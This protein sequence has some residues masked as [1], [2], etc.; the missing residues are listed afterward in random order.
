MQ[1]QKRI[2][3]IKQMLGS[4]LVI[5]LVSREFWYE[6]ASTVETLKLANLLGRGGIVSTKFCRNF[7][8]FFHFF[9]F[10]LTLKISSNFSVFWDLIP[11][12]FLNLP[13]PLGRDRGASKACKTVR[14]LMSLS[15]SSAL[16]SSSSATNWG[17]FLL[18]LVI[19]NEL[20]N[21]D[22]ITDCS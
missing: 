16:K 12:K 13:V 2:V 17:W 19:Q 11:T 22:F 5:G 6:G 21:F 8:F 14:R 15:L 1:F 10:L 3:V 9:T 18:E 20:F 4:D 7:L